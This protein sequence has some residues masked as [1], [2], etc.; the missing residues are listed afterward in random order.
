MPN[1]QNCGKE[2]LAR[3]FLSYLD[4]Y[5]DDFS[6][7]DNYFQ[8]MEEDNACSCHHCP[9]EYCYTRILAKDKYC[10]RHTV[11]YNLSQCRCEGTDW[12]GRKAYLCPQKVIT[13]EGYCYYHENQCA[14]CSERVDGRDKYCSQHWNGYCKVMDCS[15][16]TPN[17]HNSNHYIFCEQ[18][19]KLYG[20]S[21]SNYQEKKREEKQQR[22]Q[23]ATEQT[24]LK[25]LV[26]ANTAISGVI[27]EVERFSTDW[28]KNLATAITEN[29]NY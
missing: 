16:R 24:K 4:H 19:A 5:G 3:K 29:S 28:N 21:L 9:I 17:P 13:S 26:K 27:K 11:S 12:L 15:E 2:N 1:C 23:K 8:G 20:N 6:E 14:E 25:S 10:A 18:H 22:Q 7:L